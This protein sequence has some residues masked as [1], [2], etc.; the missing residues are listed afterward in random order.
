MVIISISFKETLLGYELTEY[1]GD[2]DYEYWTLANDY[3]VLL[4]KDLDE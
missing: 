3:A 2:M 1:A 4:L